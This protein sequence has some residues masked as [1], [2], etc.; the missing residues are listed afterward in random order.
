MSSISASIDNQPIIAADAT[1]PV[2]REYRKLRNTFGTE[3][4]GKLERGTVPMPAWL[5]AVE[6]QVSLRWAAMWAI[7][8]TILTVVAG[9]LLEVNWLSSASILVGAITF[10]VLLAAPFVRWLYPPI[11][12]GAVFS[13]IAIKTTSR[14]MQF[15]YG[16]VPVGC[17][18]SLGYAILGSIDSDLATQRLYGAIYLVAGAAGAFFPTI[19]SYLNGKHFP[20]RKELPVASV[21]YADADTPGPVGVWVGTAT[22]TLSAQG[23]TMGLAYG[24]QVVLK[25]RD[26]AK[27]SIAIGEIGAAKTSAM[28]V[29]WTLQLMDTGASFVFIDGK[30]EAAG[31]IARAGELIG[32]TV[33][34]IGIGALGLSLLHGLTPQQ[35]TKLIL[36]ALHLT[37]QSGS[38]SGFWTSNVATLAENALGIL[39]LEP[40]F[41]NLDALYKF[42]YKEVFR[43][44]RLTIANDQ[45]AELQARVDAG[46]K[47][48]DN[49]RRSLRICIEYFEDVFSSMN[50][51]TRND[52]NTTFGT[53]LSKFQ[54]PELIDAFCSSAQ[55]QA[56]LDDLAD[57]T[58]FVLDLPLSKY[59][60]AA[61]FVLLF[62]KEAVFR[63]VK[64]RGEMPQHDP[65]RQRMIGLIADEY[66]KIVSSTDADSLDV[67]RSLNGFVIAGTQSINA[68]ERAIG[69]EAT[70]KA[71]LA[72]FVNKLAFGSGDPDTMNYIADIIGE[73]DVMRETVSK[74][75]TVTRSFGEAGGDIAGSAMGMVFGK[76]SIGHT[77][78]V[79]ATLQRQKVITGQTFRQLTQTERSANAIALIKIADVA[80]DDV[81]VL[82]KIYFEDL[83]GE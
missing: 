1:L 14:A 72:N 15:V 32:R 49:A 35:N 24:S 12:Q 8:A 42:I 62:V 11:V 75:T 48:S 22:G 47:S 4:G 73:A 9:F 67:M 70:T 43:N 27:N 31:P 20:F 3:H 71:L 28:I 66:Q 81:L 68:M 63:L 54:N 40:Q 76:I 30:G 17:I 65:R 60:I 33:K 74:G 2:I 52:I 58:I 36:D 46:D 25:Q 37:G 64:A 45:L 78:N 61:Q 13:D 18:C 39:Q 19:A 53:V 79:S 10:N 41:Y 57:G 29:P 21:T 26:L 34:R 6:A 50:E 23:H 59:D 44:E 77:E 51:K 69:N 80:Y 38:D 16:F 82:P 5:T 56:R 7:G 83:M 55:A